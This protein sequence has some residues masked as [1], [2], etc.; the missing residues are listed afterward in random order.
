LDEAPLPRPWDPGQPEIAGCQVRGVRDYRAIVH[1]HSPHS[2]DACDGDPQPGGVLDEACLADLRAALC[3]TRIDVAFLTDHPSFATDATL[4]EMVLTRG[5][6]EPVV[7]AKGRT[8]GNWLACEGEAAG[9]RVLIIPGIE[10]GAMMPL[11][12]AEHAPAGTYDTSSPATF[13]AIREV[14]GLAWVAHTE[15]RQVDELAPLGLD[16][17]EFYQ[18]HANLD[19]DIRE[20]FLGLDPAGFLTDSIPFFFP[21]MGEGAEPDLAPLGFLVP[22]EPSITAFEALGQGQRLT[23]SAGTDAHQNVLPNLAP[24]G[25]RV[26]SYRRM[27]RWFNNRL[28]IDGPLTVESAKAALAAG[29]SHIVF[30]SFGTPQGFD[31]HARVGD[32]I[33]EMGAEVDLSAGLELVATLPTLDPRSPRAEI[34]P[35]LRGVVIRATA[36]TRE[37]IAEWSEGEKVLA[38]PGPG[39][40]RVEV[41][42]TPRH[43][44]PYLGD[45]QE[46][47]ISR[48]VPWIYSGALFVRPGA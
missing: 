47:Y 4:A 3:T 42:I 39:V 36:D 11:G 22:N 45:Y 8:V 37:V 16:G 13:Q 14:G 41:W 30:E 10:S 15:S 27:I 43:L 31:L 34:A 26:D 23:I 19:P 44:A 9:H 46:P 33:T 32:V 24:D 29:R 7:D 1:L 28:R 25:E 5:A 21:S 17:L 18:L 40:Y 48:E 12:I 35:T 38:L 20:E 2:H 6:D